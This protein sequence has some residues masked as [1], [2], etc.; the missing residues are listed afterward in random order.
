MVLLVAVIG[1]MV[2]GMSVVLVV[3][4]G[5]ILLRCVGVVVSGLE[6]LCIP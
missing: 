3:P 5:L 1:S 6:V 4:V 2:F